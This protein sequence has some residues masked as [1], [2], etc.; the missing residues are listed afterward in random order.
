MRTT[1]NLDDALLTEA[2]QVAARTGRSLTAV[3][4]DALRQSLHRRD[5][6]TRQ[7]VELPMFGEGGTQPGVDLDDSAALLDLMEQD[8]PPAG[9]AAR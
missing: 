9:D 2:K 7:V 4:E 1:I 8:D 5:P 6:A 3:V